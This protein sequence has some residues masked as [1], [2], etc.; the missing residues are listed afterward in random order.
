VCNGANCTGFRFINCSGPI[1][2][3]RVFQNPAWNGSRLDACKSFGKDCGKPAADAFCVS[4]GFRSSSSSVLDSTP[5]RGKTRII[6]NNQLC[7][8]NFCVGFQ[9]IVCH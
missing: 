3:D 5:G 4:Q 2:T 6:S 9:M 1:P 8:S 7:D